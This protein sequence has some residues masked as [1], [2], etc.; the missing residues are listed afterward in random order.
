MQFEYFFSDENLVVV[1]KAKDIDCQELTDMLKVDLQAKNVD[2]DN[3]MLV[4]SLPKEIAGI[5]VYALTDTAYRVL[6]QQALMEN[7]N[8]VAITIGDV[9]KITN[10]F[11]AS[12]ARAVDDKKY[13]YVPFG[14]YDAKHLNIEYRVIQRVKFVHAQDESKK[15]MI[16]NLVRLKGNFDDVEM[17]QFAFNE[18]HT[19]ILGDKVYAD[20][21][22]EEKAYLSIQLSELCLTHPVTNQIM[23]FVYIPKKQKPWGLF[24]LN[25]LNI[26][27][28]GNL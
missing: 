15:P 4:N 10:N 27:V 8:F 19:P 11:S 26:K 21:I 28:G 24:D 13:K 20:T 5:V 1:S 17:V 12:I 9:E 22:K 16:L 3:L 2:C 18:M 7:S 25:L 23:R 6:S 14:N